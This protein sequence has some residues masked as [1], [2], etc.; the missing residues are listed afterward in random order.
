MRHHDRLPT[1]SFPGDTTF[2]VG[3][4]QAA[5][6]QETAITV[7]GAV[8]DADLAAGDPIARLLGRSK[9][10]PYLPDPARLGH[11]M[12][13]LFASWQR[14]PLPDLRALAAALL[15][16]N[17]IAADEPLA[18]TCLAAAR[19]AAAWGGLPYHSAT[20]HAEVAINAMVLVAIADRQ[21]QPVGRHS[22]ATLLAACLG[23]DLYYQ[24]S[25]ARQRFAAEQASAEALDAMAAAAGCSDPERRTMRALVIATEPG[26]RLRPGGPLGTPLEPTAARLLG[27]ASVDP[28][29]ATLA[30]ILS[31]ADLLS[32]VGL[33]VGWYR[34]QQQRLE[35]EAGRPHR[36]GEAAVFFRDIVGTDFLSEPGRALSSNLATIRRSVCAP[37]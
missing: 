15:R 31:D 17:G 30:S 16:R 9:T 18:L 10:N 36:P 29:L 33:T 21:G 2:V 32:S 12:A 26:L 5:G 25:V 8:V 19:A 11:R 6:H 1:V 34:V 20:H 37:L 14:G 4:H 3:K 22:T 7:D 27:M 24:P 13:A 28:E 23:H 35:H